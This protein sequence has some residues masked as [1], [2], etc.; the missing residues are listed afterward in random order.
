MPVCHAPCRAVCIIV[1]ISRTSE[2][3]GALDDGGEPETYDSAV[4]VYYQL[5]VGGR[6]ARRVP[7]APAALIA[8]GA[9]GLVRCFCIRFTAGLWWLLPSIRFSFVLAFHVL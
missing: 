2:L 3:V 6:A 5:E 9:H 7:T 8:R 1:Q 4:L